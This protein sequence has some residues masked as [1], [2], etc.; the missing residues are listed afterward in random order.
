LDD[1]DAIR[2]HLNALDDID[3]KHNNKAGGPPL[4]LAWIAAFVGARKCVAEAVRRGADV[5]FFANQSTVRRLGLLKRETLLGLLEGGVSPNQEEIIILFLS[6]FENDLPT[7]GAIKTLDAIIREIGDLDPSD[8]DADVARICQSTAFSDAVPDVAETLRMLDGMRGPEAKQLKASITEQLINMAR[9]MGQE[10]LRSLALVS[11]NAAIFNEVVRRHFRSYR[12]SRAWLS[13]AASKARAELQ[14]R[15]APM[16]DLFEDDEDLSNWIDLALARYPIR[17]VILG[18]DA[19]FAPRRNDGLDFEKSVAQS[20]EEAGFHVEATPSSGDQGADVIAT[21]NG[22]RFAIQCKDYAGQVG[23][24]AVQE[25]L[26]AKAFYRTD[27]AVVCSNGGYTKSA[28]AL[29]ATSNV[30]LITPE[31]LS[32]LDKIRMLVE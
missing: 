24:A 5:E 6:D 17:E 2:E 11:T 14:S 25:V 12:K 22:L 30:L 1:I 15:L 7:S 4:T 16:M 20:L 21:S 13:A 9:T 18:S 27:Y 10:I 29:A 23:N 31:L 32:D 8:P 19:F 26:A 28:K 3:F